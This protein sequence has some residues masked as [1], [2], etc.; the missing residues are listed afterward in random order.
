MPKPLLSDTVGL[1]IRN[2]TDVCLVQLE[3]SGQVANVNP[4]QQCPYM[5]VIVSFLACLSSVSKA[6]QTC[7]HHDTSAL[8]EKHAIGFKSVGQPENRCWTFAH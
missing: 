2:M 7:A 8:Q 3:N 4:A 5:T 1:L 6:N